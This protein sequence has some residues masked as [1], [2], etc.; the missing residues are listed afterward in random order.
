MRTATG[1]FQSFDN[2]KQAIS[3][4]RGIGIPEDKIN[5]LTPSSLVTVPETVP[6]S[7]SEQTGMGK[8]VGGLVGGV[9]GAALGSLGA[10]AISLAVPGVGTVAAV[11][12]FAAALLAAG[13]AVA[14]A[15]LGG[16][17]E[18]G[19]AEGLPKDE[20]FIYED[21]LRQG[22]TVVIAL[23]EDEKQADAARDVLSKAGAESIDAA[24]KQWWVGLRDA[25]KE[26]YVAE[27]Q[28]FAKD[29]PAYQTGFVAALHPEL[30]GKPYKKA[31][32]DL[33]SRYPDLHNDRA[34]RYG[35][36]RGQEY[37]REL[38]KKHK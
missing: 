38:K 2:A 17:L 27:G 32:D 37:D 13:G 14:G 35:Y 20:L 19:L 11:G 28:D 36:D 25:E 24:R 29:E 6:T 26:K 8:A 23:A 18:K 4:L 12:F 3:G 33:R 5:L 7:A 10:A 30:R 16:A 21:A 22:R 15:A 31:E 34:F 9:S 1:V